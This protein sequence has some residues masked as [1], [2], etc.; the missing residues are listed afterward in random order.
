[1]LFFCNLL[2][3][4]PQLLSPRTI[5]LSFIL[6]INVALPGHAQQFKCHEPEKDALTTQSNYT[7]ESVTV[8]IGFILLVVKI[9]YLID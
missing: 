1:M 2:S 8:I 3:D 6:L 5:K 9:L 7:E 4:K